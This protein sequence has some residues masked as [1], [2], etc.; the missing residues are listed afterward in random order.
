MT[1]LPEHF[2]ELLALWDTWSLR[3]TYQTHANIARASGQTTA[4]DTLTQ[5]AQ[6]QD[7]IDPLQAIAANQ[8]LIRRLRA[9]QRRAMRTARRAGASWAQITHAAGTATDTGAAG[10]GWHDVVKE[11]GRPAPAIVVLCGSTRFPDAFQDANRRLTL[12]GHIVLTVG[13]YSHTAAQA[14][15]GGVG[16]DPARKAALDALHRR[17]IDLADR[18]LVLN[19]GGYIGESTRSEIAYAQAI[20]RSIEYLEPIGADR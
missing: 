10:Y 18:V 5:M 13:V 17:K 20:G 3:E 1:A 11:A 4:A 12:A 9:G 2:T 14:G 8:E 6:A 19:V 16:P 7:D 15:P